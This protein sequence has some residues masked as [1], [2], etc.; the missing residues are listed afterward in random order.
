MGSKGKLII[1]NFKLLCWKLDIAAFVIEITDKNKEYIYRKQTTCYAITIKF[2]IEGLLVMHTSEIFV[3]PRIDVV[4]KAIFGK[5][6]NVALLQSLIASVTGMPK[7]SLVEIELINPELTVDYY[8][9]KASRLDLRV[10]L[11]DGTEVDVEIQLAN[12]KSYTERILFYWSKMYCGDLDKG[13]TYEALNKCIVINFLDFEL[14]QHEKM[15]AVFHIS[16]DELG[17]R[18]TDHLEL[19]FVELPKVK[20]YNKE[21]GTENELL[22]VWTEF[23]S[24]RDESELIAMSSKELPEEVRKAFEE[25][26]E[27]SKDPAMREIALSREIALR[28][29]YQ[30]LFEAEQRGLEQG[31]EQGREQGREEGRQ[32]GLE[33]GI[34]QGIEQGK[35][36]AKLELA[37]TMK[38]Q[39]FSID[40]IQLVTGL[41]VEE[42]EKL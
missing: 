12:M 31:L 21:K 9:S 4:F 10:K 33:Q 1:S 27:L 40:Q 26:K 20:R 2:Q 17:T 38:L 23:L 11:Q 6:S 29:H 8:D 19:H 42:I 34:E 22:I 3:S 16:E 32:E 15:H 5:A 25:L 41:M 30:R 39:G 14:F 24:I 28:D 37:K 36:A 7:E 18:L 35:Q 13:S